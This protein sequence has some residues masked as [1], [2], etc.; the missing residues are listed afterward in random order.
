MGKTKVIKKA[1]PNG[2]KV[3]QIQGF[4][5]VDVDFGGGQC[6]SLHLVG[7]ALLV[8]GYNIPELEVSVY[9][10]D[11]VTVKTYGKKEA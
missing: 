2:I 1:F 9:V 11:K 10:T 7:G 6:C 5:A 3:N 4:N 8:T